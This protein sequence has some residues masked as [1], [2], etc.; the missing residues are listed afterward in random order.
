MRLNKLGALFGYL[1]RRCLVAAQSC[2]HN[3]AGLF[4]A[5][6]G[7]LPCTFAPNLP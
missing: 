2:L 4:G 1:S 6:L 7:D 5:L 3:S